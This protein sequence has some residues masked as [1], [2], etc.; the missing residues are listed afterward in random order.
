VIEL[1]ND[2]LSLNHLIGGAGIGVHPCYTSA[3]PPTDI[4]PTNYLLGKGHLDCDSLINVTVVEPQL[5]IISP[6]PVRDIV[7]IS[8]IYPQQITLY[9]WLGKEMLTK[10]GYTDKI[11]MTHLPKGLYFLH[12]ISD[13]GAVYVHKLIKQ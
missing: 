7:N 11:N 12:I 2:L 9:D 4:S 5:P 10:T 6:N 3:S 13:T 1:Y 8:G